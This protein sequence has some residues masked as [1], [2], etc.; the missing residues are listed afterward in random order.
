MPKSPTNENAA[1]D[2][3]VPKT[4][5]PS[6]A[7]APKVIEPAKPGATAQGPKVIRNPQIAPVVL[8]KTEK[9]IAKEEEVEVKSLALPK[10][11]KESIALLQRTER[12]PA[13]TAVEQRRK[14]KALDI[15]RGHVFQL[16]QGLPVVAMT[17]NIIAGTSANPE[18]LK[19]ERLL[20]RSRSDR[21]IEYLLSEIERLEKE[22]ETLKT[23]SEP[24]K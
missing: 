24:A 12:T 6:A 18:S 19:R 11:L 16:Q 15:I 20:I 1:D 8:P 13:K 10:G 7:V 14:A 17:A 9:E 22:I 23:T 4:T 3:E 2:F 21:D 5:Q